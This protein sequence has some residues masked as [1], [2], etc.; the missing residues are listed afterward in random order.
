MTADAI[1]LPGVGHFKDAMVS[2]HSKGLD[3]I[4]KD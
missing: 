4:L 1:V 2:I 3:Q